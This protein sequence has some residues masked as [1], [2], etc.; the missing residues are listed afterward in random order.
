VAEGGGERAAAPVASRVVAQELRVEAMLPAV[1]ADLAVGGALLEER[2]GGDD[3]KTL[4]AGAIAVRAIPLRFGSA[5]ECS[6]RARTRPVRGSRRT[7]APH[8][9]R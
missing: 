6:A 4:A 2:G 5:R 9:T 8:G 3:L 1:P 7:V